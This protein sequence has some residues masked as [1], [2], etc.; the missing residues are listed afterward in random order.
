MPL[1]SRKPAK[2]PPLES[3]DASIVP[4]GGS[5]MSLVEETTHKLSFEI[6]AGVFEG[7]ELLPTE[8]QLITRF[9][10]SRTVVR[11]ATKQ[12]VSRGLVE[13]QHGRGVKIVDNLHKPLNQSFKLR[14]PNSKDRLEKL[15]EVRRL[16]EPFVARL[17][18]MRVQP[19]QLE[20]L[21]D[22][23]SRQHDNIDAAA[24]AEIDME[25]HRALTKAA[26]NEVF[27]LM[28]ESVADLGHES[29]LATISEF[30]WRQAHES[31][32][33]ILSAIEKRDGDAAQIA[34]AKHV[35]MAAV[36]LRRHFSSSARNT[37]RQDR[38]TL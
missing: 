23:Q 12:L 11:E 37:K 27:E 13:I 5:R 30:G 22:L 14:L 3:Q 38:T 28:L 35:E 10:V 21:H 36:D 34:M 20:L 25:F 33:E 7:Q 18:A 9:R 26:G 16:V 17:A 24:A 15:M 4:A 8:E 29:R 6:M 19:K 32:A 1:K 2:R 31:H